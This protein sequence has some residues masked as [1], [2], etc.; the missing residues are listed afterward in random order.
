MT[1][2]DL[3]VDKADAGLRGVGAHIKLDSPVKL[4]DHD[5]SH[6]KDPAFFPRVEFIV[7]FRAKT[8]CPG[9]Y[10]VSGCSHFLKNSY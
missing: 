4:Q 8:F 1:I 9:A 2:A 3:T 10:W 7:S 6:G 5:Y